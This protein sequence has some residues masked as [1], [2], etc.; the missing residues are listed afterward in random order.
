[1]AVE[2]TFVEKKKYFHLKFQGK[3][4]VEDYKVFVPQID[5]ATKKYGEI[6]L[7]MELVDFHGWTL[8]ASWEDAKFGFKHITDIKRIAVLGD[9]T[10]E[11]GLSFLLKLFTFAAVR[12]FPL[13]EKQEAKKWIESA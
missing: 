9:E 13:H 12:Y 4:S 10:W 6:S 5:A 7:L 1:M 3:L 11:K 2:C 8:G